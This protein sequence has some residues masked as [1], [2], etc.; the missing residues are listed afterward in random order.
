MCSCSK[1]PI[2]PCNVRT[3]WYSRPLRASV[4]GS[5]DSEHQTPC[6]RHPHRWLC[7]CA[8]QPGQPPSRTS[9]VSPSTCRAV[10]EAD[11]RTTR[12]VGDGLRIDT[13][14]AVAVWIRHGWAHCEYH[15]GKRAMPHRA[16]TI[17]ASSSPRGSPFSRCCPISH[18]CPMRRRTTS[19]ILLVPPCWRKS[20]CTSLRRRLSTVLGCS[21]LSCLVL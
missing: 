14:K 17:H 19:E 12:L 10:N 16:A 18:C 1:R 13:N 15:T 7:A 2:T 4:Q 21:S 20:D 3:R 9:Y 8:I 5:S 11:S 6:W